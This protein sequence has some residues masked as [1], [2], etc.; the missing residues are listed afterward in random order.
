MYTFE[1][2]YYCNYKFFLCVYNVIFIYYF[3]PN[4]YYENRENFKNKFVHAP[5]SC[6][7]FPETLK[8]FNDSRKL[9]TQNRLLYMKTKN[10]SSL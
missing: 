3:F 2:Q 5:N 10:K 8:G 4:M 1:R 7:L 6:D 9:S